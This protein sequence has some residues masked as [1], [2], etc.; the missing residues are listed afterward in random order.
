MKRI[1]KRIMSIILVLVI[2]VVIIPSGAVAATADKT[3]INS[4]DI[5][6]I[7]ITDDF[8]GYV[9]MNKKISLNSYSTSEAVYVEDEGIGLSYFSSN[10][11]VALVDN[12][13]LVHLIG[14]GYASI[15]ATTE[16]GISD[17]CKIFVGEKIEQGKKY[18]LDKT[19]TDQYFYF[20]PDTAG[21]Y[22]LCLESDEYYINCERTDFSPVSGINE[23]HY[24]FP[25]VDS[26]EDGQSMIYR[27]SASS[28]S[29]S[30]A[31]DGYFYIEKTVEAQS[32]DLEVYNYYYG[33]A[34]YDNDF[35]ACVGD[36]LVLSA[37]FMPCNGI[38]TVTYSSS[39]SGVVKIDNTANDKYGRYKKI[40]CIGVGSAR[41]TAMTETGKSSFIDITVK[42]RKVSFEQENKTGVKGISDE[43]S[44]QISNFDYDFAHKL[45]F[46]S[47]DETVVK[48]NGTNFDKYWGSYVDFEYVGLGNTKIIC[49]YNGNIVASCDISVSEPI[50]IFVGETVNADSSIDKLYYKVSPTADGKYVVDDDGKIENI[51][52]ISDDGTLEKID[53]TQNAGMTYILFDSGKNYIICFDNDNVLEDYTFSI[54]KTI[55]ATSMAFEYKDLNIFYDSLI[56]NNITNDVIFYPSNAENESISLQSSDESILEINDDGTM[57]AK[58]TG[59]VEVFATSESGLVAKCSINILNPMMASENKNLYIEFNSN[60]LKGGTVYH[61][62]P[63]ITGE[64][65]IYTMGNANTAM[66]ITNID[67]DYIGSLIPE[68]GGNFVGEV[69]LNA[70]ERYI[71][72]VFGEPENDG[73]CKF[74]MRIVSP[75]A[76]DILIGDVNGDGVVDSLD[77]LTLSRYF[78]NWP[79]YSADKIDMDAADVNCD[80]VVNQ[81]DRVIL[82]RHLANWSGYETLP[83]IK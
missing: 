63:S 42:E 14:E 20:A 5:T 65:K 66:V 71:L 51:Y 22:V 36:T 6:E 35:E 8:F 45:E 46:Q 67:S 70:G 10:E 18:K 44:I 79:D 24:N 32:I 52:V 30:E 31:C 82:S 41:I 61:F 49:K 43:L 60:E 23:I 9:G 48:I 76:S 39:N 19:R 38:S 21:D 50:E 83:Y 81:L 34:S 55:K 33:S 7:S 40:E 28:E 37:S 11:N 1:T 68:N 13:G 16:N 69:N 72:K 77:S 15:T 62:T 47:M 26:Y 57:K 74:V 80:G 64:Y 78:A 27:L 54:D 53:F 75:G 73:V 29:S 56:S 3:V 25:L 59:S 4:S 17:D 2:T 12:D 58:G